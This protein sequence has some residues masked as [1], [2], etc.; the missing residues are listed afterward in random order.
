V[1]TIEFDRGV[2]Q[3]LVRCPSKVICDVTVLSTMVLC[4]FCHLVS[5]ELFPS[6]MYFEVIRDEEHKM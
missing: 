4:R 3:G 2:A 1:T 5:F 6:D